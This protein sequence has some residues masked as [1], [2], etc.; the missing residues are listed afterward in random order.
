MNVGVKRFLHLADAAGK[1][2]DGFACANFD[3]LKAVSGEPLG[4][5]LHVRIGGPELCAELLGSEP[6]VIIRGGFILLVVEQLAEGGFLVGAALQ[7]D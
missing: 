6:G 4:Y 7:E 3:I 2:D 5:G 1:F